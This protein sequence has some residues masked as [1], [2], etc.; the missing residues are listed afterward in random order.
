MGWDLTEFPIPKRQVSVQKLHPPT[1]VFTSLQQ[2]YNCVPVRS[3]CTKWEQMYV[4]VGLV[5]GH[6]ETISV[7][8]ETC[9][10]EGER[11]PGCNTFIAQVDET[12]G[13]MRSE[14]PFVR[15]DQD[16]KYM[17]ANRNVFITV[18]VAYVEKFL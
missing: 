17:R 9:P 14:F 10:V 6:T 1:Q 15:C 5:L 13:S 3:V 8:K 16:Y 4:S 18:T 11:L 12:S 2:T 7:S